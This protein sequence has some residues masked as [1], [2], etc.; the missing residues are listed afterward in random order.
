M[1]ED[2]AK[3]QS[4]LVEALNVTQKS[5]SERLHAMGK[6]KKEGKRV[7]HDLAQRPDNFAEKTSMQECSVSNRRG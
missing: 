5:V 7:P 2:S 1:E 4:Q 3:T 6:I